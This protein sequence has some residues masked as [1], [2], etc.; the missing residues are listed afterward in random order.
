VVVPARQVRA[1]RTELAWDT[2]GAL[3]EMLQT[4]WG[5]LTR[6]LR[7]RDGDRLLVRGGTSSVGL[8]AVAIAKRIGARVGGPTRPPPPAAFLRESGADDVVVD[9]GAIAPEVYAR[10]G[11]VDKVLELV[12]TT[13][14]A[15]SL[16]C[17]T[18]PGIVSM[19]GMVGNAWSIA[20][21]SPMDVIP[22]S[23]CLTTYDGGVDDF[24]R[25]PLQALVD[26]IAAGQL[27]VRVGKVFPLERIADAHR[28]MEA[29]EGGGKI[30]VTT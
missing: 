18:E 9:T 1:V 10:W 7:L 6:S 12:G 29:N 27:S 17:V 25:M 14:L 16:Q 21:F 24:M 8:A 11:G 23:V 19:T 28:A 15:D 4:A 30:V 20:D 2:L 5:A 26:D 22:N 13:T 3:P